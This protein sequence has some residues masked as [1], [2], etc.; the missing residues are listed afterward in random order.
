MPWWL[1]SDEDM[2]VIRNALQRAI[3]RTEADC[4][5]ERCLCRYKG[6]PCSKFYSDALH[7]L[8]SGL[9]QTDAVPTDWQVKEE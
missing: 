2:Q 6:A 5:K 1:I 4:N 8:D 3:L 9:H 7:T